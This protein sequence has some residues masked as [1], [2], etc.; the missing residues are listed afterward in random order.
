MFFAIASHVTDSAE[1]TYNIV[2]R[3]IYV[4]K[5]FMILKSE[6]GYSAMYVQNVDRIFGKFFVAFISSTIRYF[7]FENAKKSEI[8]TNSLIRKLNLLEIIRD[9]FLLTT[10]RN[11]MISASYFLN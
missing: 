7:L 10:I 2:R 3:K 9:K 5:T 6:L 1:K 11:V 4:E 8:N